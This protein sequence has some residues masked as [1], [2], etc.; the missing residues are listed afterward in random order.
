M[1][2]FFLLGD[3]ATDPSTPITRREALRLLTLNREEELLDSDSPGATALRS[4][5]D[6]YVFCDPYAGDVDSVEQ[7]LWAAGEDAAR[8]FRD[9]RA[10]DI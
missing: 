9:Q 4:T 2:K 7:Y 1:A 6:V 3:T 5:Q 10:D 8:E